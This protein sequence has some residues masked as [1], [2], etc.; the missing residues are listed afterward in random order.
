MKLLKEILTLAALLSAPYVTILAQAADHGKVLVILSSSQQLELRDGKT[1]PT[2]YY[3][4]EL[5]IPLHKI[6]GCRLH[7]RLRQP[8]RQRGQV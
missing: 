4:D 2:G 6:I 7:A 3:L 8:Q 1:Y 5:E